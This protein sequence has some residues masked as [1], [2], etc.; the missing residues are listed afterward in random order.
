MRAGRLRPPRLSPWRVSIAFCSDRS[1]TLFFGP[2]ATIVVAGICSRCRTS[3]EARRARGD[4]DGDAVVP[5]GRAALR[6][7]LS[8]RVHLAG[9]HA[10]APVGDAR[11][12]AAARRRG[13]AGR[14]PPDHRRARLLGLYVGWSGYHYSGQSLGLAMLYPLRQGARLEVRE[15]RLI[16]LPLYVSWMLSLLGL[17]RLSS[18]ARNPAYEA[19]RR[20]YLGPPLP[21][22]GVALGLAALAASLTGVSSWRARG[23]RGTPLPWPTYAVLSAQ[24]SW[25]TI[26]L[27]QPL[28]NI[29]LVPM[30]HGLQYLALTSWHT[31]RRARRRRAVRRLPAGGVAAGPGHQPGLLLLVQGPDAARTF[32]ATAAVISFVNLHHFLLDGRIWRLRERRVVDGRVTRGLTFA[33]LTAGLLFGALAVCACLMPAQSDTFWHLRAGQEIWRTHHVP[34]V[35]H[36]SYTAS[37][38]FWPNHEWLWQ[39]L[40]YALYRIGGM[41]LYVLGGAAVA[42]GAMVLVYRMMVGEI[43]DPL[44]ADAGGVPADLGHLGAA[45]ADRDPAFPRRHG[46]AAR[47]RARPGCLPLLFLIWANAHGGVAFGG[48]VLLRRHRGG[49]AARAA[50]RSRRRA[51]RAPPLRRDAAVRSRHTAHAARVWGLGV[52]R[53]IVGPVAQERNHRVAAHAPARPVR[54]RVLGGGVAFV[55]LLVGKRGRLRAAPSQSWGW[56]DTVILTAALVTLPL[57][58]LHGAKYG[59]VPLFAIPAASRL[60]GPEFRFRRAP[61]AATSSEQSSLEPGSAD[62]H[63]AGR[64][65]RRAGDLARAAAQDGLAPDEPRRRRGGARLPRAHLQSFL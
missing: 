37:G 22:W 47:R 59:D 7:D 63:L 62:G 55:A 41:P 43:A 42:M 60:L 17:F 40:S 29:L 36:Y 2:G 53:W 15:K 1:P 25:F 32:M 8:A 3:A 64:A 34:L 61:A 24:I 12:A 13:V 50:S 35:D 18:S 27:Y 33:Q 26:G 49:A 48:L 14:S 23:A 21:T 38:R 52:R 65:R 51:A 10:R 31:T 56:G 45:A 39:A 11:G 16:R 4:V 19:I 57:G 20:A 9:D 30:F 28:F 6:G 5:A 44:L 58:I 54:D 46:G